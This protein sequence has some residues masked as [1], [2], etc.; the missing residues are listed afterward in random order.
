M[1]G[2]MGQEQ[3]PWVPSSSG[4]LWECQ[5]GLRKAW[6]GWRKHFQDGSITWHWLVHWS[7][8]TWPLCGSLGVLMPRPLAAL[9]AGWGRGRREEEEAKLQCLYE[10]PHPF[11]STLSRWSSWSAP[12]MSRRRQRGRGQNIRRE[13]HWGPFGSELPCDHGRLPSVSLSTSPSL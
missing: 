5:P 3:L 6:P 11:I 12:V 10:Q 13:A 4:L 8:A 9:R 1:P 7:L 2:S